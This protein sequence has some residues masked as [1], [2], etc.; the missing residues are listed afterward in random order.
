MLTRSKTALNNQCHTQLANLQSV[1]NNIDTKQSI[2][3]LFDHLEN[4]I[5]LII[6]SVSQ[7]IDD[8]CNKLIDETYKIEEKLINRKPLYTVVDGEVISHKPFTPIRFNGHF[9]LFQLQMRYHIPYSIELDK[10]MLEMIFYYE[11]LKKA[12]VTVLPKLHYKED[13][14]LM[15]VCARYKTN[16]YKR[17][18]VWSH[19]PNA[20]NSI[21]KICTKCFYSPTE[22]NVVEYVDDVDSDDDTEEDN[23]Y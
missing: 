16:N 3:N 1:L 2:E 20:C 5:E 23:D 9:F 10:D 12:I 21:K 22:F 17:K 19:A 8:D 18:S 14:C 13:S 7:R 6:E 11:S 4:Q 15:S